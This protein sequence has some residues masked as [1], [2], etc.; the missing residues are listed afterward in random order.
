[1]VACRRRVHLLADRRHVAEDCRVQKSCVQHHI[2]TQTSLLRPNIWTS[3]KR[4]SNYIL[5]KFEVSTTLR[6]EI[7][8]S[9]RDS[10]R[11]GR[12]TSFR[13]IMLQ[14]NMTHLQ[15]SLL[16][17]NICVLVKRASKKYL[18]QIRSFCNSSF[19]AQNGT[20][21]EMN[22]LCHSVIRQGNITHLHGSAGVL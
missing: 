16:R 9:E 12:T 18:H 14:G 20:H 13:K 3:V 21:R 7:S 22:G 4:A 10:Q 19:W 2:Q 1:M 17:P 11:G 8:S 6:S 5:S 15:T